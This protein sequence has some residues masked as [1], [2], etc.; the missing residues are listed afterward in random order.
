MAASVLGKPGSLEFYK[1]TQDE[2]RKKLAELKAQAD[3]CLT[4]LKQRDE[5]DVESFMCTICTHLDPGYMGALYHVQHE[6]HMGQEDAE[7]VIQKIYL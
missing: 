5:L 2:L 7:K 6:H 4:I 3:L 1:L